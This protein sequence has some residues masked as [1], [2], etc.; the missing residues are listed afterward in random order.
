MEPKARAKDKEVVICPR[1]R[2]VGG[3]GRI[4]IK[5]C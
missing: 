3:S 4:P 5:V 1:G 2:R